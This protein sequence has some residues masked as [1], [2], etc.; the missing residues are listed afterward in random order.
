MTQDKPISEKRL[1]EIRAMLSEIEDA[2]ER[3]TGLRMG[4]T[5]LRGERPRAPM[6]QACYDL[7]ADVEWRRS[8]EAKA[9][10]QIERLVLRNS[11]LRDVVRVVAEA[12]NSDNSVCYQLCSYDMH[13]TDDE[14]GEHQVTTHNA[15][16]V[17]EQARAALGMTGGSG[18]VTTGEQSG[19]TGDAS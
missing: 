2:R 7:L 11:E 13:W 18:E 8:Q 17:V 16:C 19:D 10:E 6:L 3:L 14:H 4:D 15:P 9:Q 12:D 1:A 5:E